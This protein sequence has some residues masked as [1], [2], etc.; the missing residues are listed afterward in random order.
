MQ[1]G[2][3]AEHSY[4]YVCVRVRVRAPS[5]TMIGKNGVISVSHYETCVQCGCIQGYRVQADR[6]DTGAACGAGALLHTLGNH[7]RWELVP[8]AADV[9]H[10]YFGTRFALNTDWSKRLCQQLVA[11]LTTSGLL[12]WAAAVAVASQSYINI[13]SSDFNNRVVPN[14]HS[15]YSRQQIDTFPTTFLDLVYSTI[16][17]KE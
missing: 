8:G 16:Y 9:L 7:Q 2:Y 11:K 1:S 17:R 3:R 13:D 5:K 12:L 6:S 4:E 10:E 14:Y 15:L